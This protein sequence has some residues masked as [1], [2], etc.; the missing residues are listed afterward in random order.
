MILPF[1]AGRA[2]RTISTSRVLFSHVAVADQHYSEPGQYCSLQLEAMNN[3][4]ET[5]R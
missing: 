4:R 2:K 1:F 3:D 5:K